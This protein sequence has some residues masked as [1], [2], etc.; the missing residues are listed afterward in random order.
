MI[1]GTCGLSGGRNG[2]VG[3]RTKPYTVPP[4]GCC[5]QVIRTDALEEAVAAARWS[6]YHAHGDAAG[7]RRHQRRRRDRV[8]A[9]PERRK[10]IK[11]RLER[12]FAGREF[13]K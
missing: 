5:G 10:Q 9:W 11:K 3:F 6:L 1:I 2:I 12:R 8:V 4:I 13:V 7:I